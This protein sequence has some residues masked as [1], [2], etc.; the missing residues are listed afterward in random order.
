MTNDNDAPHTADTLSKLLLDYSSASAGGNDLLPHGDDARIGALAHEKLGPLGAVLASFGDDE[1]SGRAV[2]AMASRHLLEQQV[3]AYQQQ[4]GICAAIEKRVTFDP[5]GWEATYMHRAWGLELIGDDGDRIQRS[6]HNL[7]AAFLELA[8]GAAAEA[9]WVRLIELDRDEVCDDGVSREFVYYLP[10]EP[11]DLEQEIS[12]TTSAYVRRGADWGAPV[13]E[14]Q[15]V[16]LHLHQGLYPG[17][18]G[19]EWEEG[20]TTATFL[21]V[22]PD[23]VD[24]VRSAEGIA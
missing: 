4:Q 2:R 23:A 24:A 1:L 10:W 6:A 14:D 11:A 8:M 22:R 15:A 5:L 16:R 13:T 18:D 19:K 21:L 3:H 17:D 9:G 12:R 20:T 7:A